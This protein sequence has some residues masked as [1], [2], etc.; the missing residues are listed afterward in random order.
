MSI[1][2]NDMTMMNQTMMT[3]SEDHSIQSLLKNP[4]LSSQQMKQY[5]LGNQQSQSKKPDATEFSIQPRQ[6]GPGMGADIGGGD[7]E[8]DEAALFQDLLNDKKSTKDPS[9]FLSG[10]Q[11]ALGGQ[12]GV[13]IRDL[14]FI[15]K[16]DISNPN[17]FLGSVEGEKQAQGLREKYESTDNYNYF[18]DIVE[19]EYDFSEG[20]DGEL[21]HSIRGMADATIKAANDADVALPPDVLRTM[22]ATA[23]ESPQYEIDEISEKEEEDDSDKSQS[24]GGQGSDI[25]AK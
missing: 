12:L 10:A 13:G 4:A 6:M 25:T 17:S 9:S 16:N 21:M 3:G 19:E 14:S 7:P 15:T 20:E 22:H 23:R 18:K 8:Q 2:L 24:S 11:V 5:Q 1:D